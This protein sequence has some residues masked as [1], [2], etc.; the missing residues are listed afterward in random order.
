M[1]MWRSAE[2]IAC[3]EDTYSLT[4]SQRNTTAE[5]V[6]EERPR[7]PSYVSDAEDSIEKVKLVFRSSTTEVTIRI[8]VDTTCGKAVDLFVKKAGL[9]PGRKRAKIVVDGD[10]QDDNATIG[11]LDLEDGDMVEITGI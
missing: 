6:P 3:D 10:K 7:S 1:K 2:V 4:R 8:P 9:Q 5:T 11:S